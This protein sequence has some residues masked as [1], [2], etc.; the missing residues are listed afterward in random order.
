[1]IYEFSALPSSSFALLSLFSLDLFLSSG[2][3]VSHQRVVGW[4]MSCRLPCQ[5]KVSSTSFH[6]SAGWLKT[7][8]MVWLPDCSMY[9]TP[10]WSTLPAKWVIAPKIWDLGKHSVSKSWNLSLLYLYCRLFIQPQLSQVTLSMQ[11]PI[12]TFSS[13]CSE[14]MGARRKCY[15]LKMRIG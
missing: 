7:G 14:T 12:P 6:V 13:L 9:W 2:I 1:M 10:A 8:E 11:G 15:Y 4:W 3:T 5:P